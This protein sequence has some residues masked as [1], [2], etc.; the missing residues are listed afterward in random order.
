MY[1][2]MNYCTKTPKLNLAPIHLPFWR[3]EVSSPFN[4][5][6]DICILKAFVFCILSGSIYD[7]G[8]FCWNIN[9]LREYVYETE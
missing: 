8:V 4:Q 1:K 6:G 3:A 9:F 5:C 2:L 7:I